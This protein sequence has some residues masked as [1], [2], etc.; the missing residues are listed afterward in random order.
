MKHYRLTL[1]T[2]LPPERLY[3]VEC[4]ETRTPEIIRAHSSA[5]ARQRIRNLLSLTPTDVTRIEEETDE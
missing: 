3:R 1:P 5:E 2:D 4:A